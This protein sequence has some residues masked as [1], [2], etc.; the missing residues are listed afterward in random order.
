M[1]SLPLLA[2]CFLTVLASKARALEDPTGGKAFTPWLWEDQIRP[3]L[4]TA[5]EAGQLYLLAGGSALTAISFSWDDM[6]QEF[7]ADIISQK[8]ATLSSKLS[9]GPPLVGLALV[10]ILFDQ[11]A[12]LA[13]GRAIALTALS[14]ITLAGLIQRERPNHSPTRLSFPSGH[15]SH[16]FA[17]ATSLA[18]AYG[19]W[20]GG[21]SYAAAVWCSLGRIRDKAH[22]VSDVFAGAL[23]G[24]YWGRASALADARSGE[25]VG[26]FVPFLQPGGGGL[27]WRRDF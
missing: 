1:K 2:L 14:H 16:V 26:E 5:G 15:V 6:G 4:K 13:H 27:A 19:P 11:K 25:E 8:Q 23:L 24:I 10:Q 22:W 3:T 17:S 12:G 9:S 18:Y 7:A 20:V 21:F